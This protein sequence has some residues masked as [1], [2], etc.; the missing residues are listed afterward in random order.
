MRK[1][2][3]VLARLTSA[4]LLVVGAIFTVLTLS[5]TGTHPSGIRFL[6]TDLP[7]V[8]PLSLVAGALAVPGVAI[9]RRRRALGG[10]LLALS[11]G[12]TLFNLG[13]VALSPG[14]SDGGYVSLLLA[15]S[16]IALLLALI[17]TVT[18]RGTA[19]FLGGLTGAFLVVV[20]A[21]I[22]IQAAFDKNQGAFTKKDTNIIQE[23][24]P[25]LILVA[26]A[27]ALPGAIAGWG[28]RALGGTLLV[29]SIGCILLLF[30]SLSSLEGGVY[31]IFVF[32]PLII[33][34]AVALL[35]T[36][37]PKRSPSPPQLPRS[38]AQ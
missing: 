12:C 22:T 28:H 7:W 13:G 20:G 4:L 15:A 14:G 8:G 24:W 35:A 23:H 17:L 21:A 25:L 38:P 6:A 10:T 30:V 16:S 34:V 2:A 5:T 31:I 11:L 29:L 27:L 26:G 33:P 32:A 18:V 37:I 9:G 3:P 36:A 19:L 1:I